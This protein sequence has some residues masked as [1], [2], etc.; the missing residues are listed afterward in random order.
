M[1]KRELIDAMAENSELSKKDCEAALD[2][3]TQAVGA[4]LKEGEKVQLTGFGS[5]E[6]KARGERTGRNPKTKEAITIAASKA[7]V[8]KAGKALKEAVQ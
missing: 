1:N 7:P 5:F 2:A 3:F 8:F 4:A 6:V